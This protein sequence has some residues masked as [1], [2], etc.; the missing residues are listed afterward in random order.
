MHELS[1]V[2]S[3]IDIASRELQ[4]ASASVIE[5]IELEIGTLSSIEMES[6][7]FAWQQAVKQTSLENAERIIHSIKGVARCR[8]CGNEF[9]VQQYY[10]ECPACNQHS[11]DITSGKELRVKSLTVI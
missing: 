8:C 9:P 1:V 4:K 5:T 7:D 3:I 11:V 2:M 10:Q 6:F